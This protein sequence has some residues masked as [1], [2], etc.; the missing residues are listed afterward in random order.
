MTTGE[1]DTSE[2]LDRFADEEVGGPFVESSSK[3]EFAEGS[4]A[5]NP[6]DA[7]REPFPK[8]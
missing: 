7:T 3:Q 5:S 1:D 6:A 8:T 2:S 4:D